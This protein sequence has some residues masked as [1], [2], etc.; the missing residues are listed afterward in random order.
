MIRLTF[1][2]HVKWRNITSKG[3]YHLISVSRFYHSYSKSVISA[4]CSLIMQILST[5][6]TLIV[7]DYV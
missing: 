5:K 3:S 1:D 4:C 2:R 7:L 6:S